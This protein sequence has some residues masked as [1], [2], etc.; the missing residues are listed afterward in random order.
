MFWLAKIRSHFLFPKNKRIFYKISRDPELDWLC[1]VKNFK[2]GMTRPHLFFVD[3]Q[4]FFIEF[5]YF[6]CFIRKICC[7]FAPRKTIKI[8]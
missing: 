7:I 8:Y 4:Y 2:R 3:Y 1:R 5:R 6:F